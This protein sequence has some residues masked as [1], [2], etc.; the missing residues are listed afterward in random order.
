M[1]KTT[2]FATFWALLIC[3]SIA[4]DLNN[5]PIQGIQKESFR[6]EIQLPDIPGYKTLKCDFHIHTV[7]SDGLVWPTVRVTEAWEE[8]LDAIAITDHIEYKPHREFVKGDH[9][10]SYEIARP[11]AEA[12][13]LILVRGGEITR[14]MPPGH[15]NGL[16]LEDVNALDKKEAFEAIREVDRQGG[17]IQWNHPG[18]KAQ[19]PDTCLWMDMHQ[20]LFEEGL[21]H[22]IEV[23][24]HTEW[25]PV[26][27]DW[28]LN[29]NLSV[30]GNSDIHKVTAH[31][32]HLNDS[33]RPMTLVFAKERTKESLKEAMFARRTVAWFDGKMAGPEKLLKA[34]FK[35]SLEIQQFKDSNKLKIKN[36]ADM[37]FELSAGSQFNFTIPALGEVYI[38][39]PDKIEKVN[40]RNLYTQSTQCLTIDL[41]ELTR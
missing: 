10:S 6:K 28:C 9:N 13:D 8:G 29:K 2:L 22:G 11:L 12:K 37:P 25:Y 26:A 21:I 40:I 7:F 16:F 3:P 23:F 27:L 4:Q 32:Y 18:W 20:Q 31:Q 39:V 15:L 19:Q 5:A 14:G 1:K 34:F 30:L 38:T 35:A 33:H 41:K 36:I 24:N 17:F